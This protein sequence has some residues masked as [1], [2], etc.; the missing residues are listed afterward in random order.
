MKALLALILLG[1]LGYFAYGKYQADAV[2]TEIVDPVF[3]EMRVDVKAQGRELEFVLYGK[4]ADEEDCR[5]RAGIVWDKAIAGC[6]ECD[7]AVTNCRKELAPRYAKLF[8]DQPIRSTYMSFTR[9][10]QDERDGRMVIYGL[11]ADEGDAICEMI[12][13]QAQA[14]YSGKVECVPARRD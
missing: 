14:E 7:L 9:G 2:P 11:T 13:K 1:A 10:N 3:A 12:R 4:M 6:R 5:T 8:D